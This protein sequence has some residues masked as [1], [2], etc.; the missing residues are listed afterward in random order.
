[1]AG[2]TFDPFA[3]E[4]PVLR[5]GDHGEWLLADITK[6]NA[7]KLDDLI[8]E[9]NTLAA[10]PDLEVS[11]VAD[12]TGQILEA[13]CENSDGLHETIV[14]LADEDA[15][16]ERGADGPLGVIALR[17]AVG[18]VLEWIYGELSAGEG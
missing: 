8:G 16:K 15:A 10:D 4:R 17:G 7:K 5:L 3:I 13:A 18:F 6:S 11:R 14:A 2:K 9:F 1:M 12:I